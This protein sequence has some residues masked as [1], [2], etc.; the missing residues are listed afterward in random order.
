MRTLLAAYALFSIGAGVMLFYLPLHLFSLG[1]SLFDVALL[2]TISALVSALLSG[3]WGRVSDLM[4][5]RKP[6][7][8]GGMAAMSLFF[9]SLLLAI[10]TK[11]GVLL[12][13]GMATAFTCVTEPAIQA[14]LTSVLPKEKGR[15]A[16]RMNAYNYAG[17]SA[18]AL[19]G[20]FLYDRFGFSPLAA[21]SALSAAAA[22]L[23]L[24]LGFREKPGLFP[25]NNGRSTPKAGNMWRVIARL[26]PLYLYVFLFI[27]GMSTFGP[28]S[29]VYLVGLGNSRSVYG[30]AC[31]LSF[32]GAGLVSQK[33]G[34]MADSHGR[35]MLLIAGG[36]SY[37]AV[38]AFV[39]FVKSPPSL[40]L[41]AW[42]IPL[43]PLGW[44]AATALVGDKTKGEDRGAGMGLL[45]SFKNVGLVT[46]SLAGGI[47]AAGGVGNVLVFAAIVSAMAALLAVTSSEF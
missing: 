16:G 44:I 23:I 14:Y 10:R 28:I 9:L 47:L 37:V 39:Y 36:L 31:F 45:N 4:R 32:V 6:F 35:K 42:S 21:L 43:Y 5:T 1:G 29:P 11:T 38:F 12:A 13:L 34:R 24:L 17:I 7:I 26:F 30:I 3:V 27:V 18:S 46:G 22:T 40:P 19:F 25:V 41:I 2:T 20:G 8:V 33:I 15:A